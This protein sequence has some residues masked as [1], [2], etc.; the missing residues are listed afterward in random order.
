MLEGP[1]WE[2]KGMVEY[3]Q[4]VG[5]VGAGSVGGGGGAGGHVVAMERREKIGAGRIGGGGG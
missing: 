2:R 4:C 5:I 3:E 1:C